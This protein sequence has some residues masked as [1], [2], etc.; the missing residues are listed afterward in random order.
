MEGVKGR[1]MAVA[2]CAVI[3]GFCAVGQGRIF[4]VDDDAVGAG[5][6]SSWGDAFVS[7]LDALSVAVSGDEIHVA[8]GTYKPDRGASFIPPNR[9]ETFALV[10]GVALLGGYAGVLTL[11]PD[12]RDIDRYETILSGDL[13]GDDGPDFTNYDDNS[14]QGVVIARGIRDADTAIEGFTITGGNGDEG[15][16]IICTES[17][18]Q[19]RQCKVLGNR[20][21]GSGG[22]MASYGGTLVLTDCAFENNRAGYHGGGLWHEGGVLSLAQCS[23]E[24]NEAHGHGGGL[25]AVETVVNLLQCAFRGNAGLSDSGGRGRVVSSGGGMYIQP[26]HGSACT[27]CSFVGNDAKSHGGGAYVYS[28]GVITFHDCSFEDNSA[29]RGGGLANQFGDGMAMTDCVFHNNS[30]QRDGGGIQSQGNLALTRCIF[31]RNTASRG[32]G[33]ETTFSAPMLRDCVFADNIA[34]DTD[35]PVFGGGAIYLNGSPSNPSRGGGDGIV[36]DMIVPILVGCRFAGNRAIG[37]SGGALF[38]GAIEAI[39]TNCIFIGNTASDGGGV[40]SY[41]FGTTLRYCTLAQNRSDRISGISDDVGQSVC[42]H[43]IVW[44]HTGA[45]LSDSVSASFSDI[46]HGWPGEGN[47]DV[48]PLFA[49]PGYWGYDVDNRFVPGKDVWVDGD[50]HLVSQAG[51]WDPEAEA[52]VR[53]EVTSPCIDAGNPEGPIGDELFPNGGIANMGA[54]GGSTQASKTYF[55]TEPAEVHLAGDINGDGAVG[56]ADLLIV[57]LQWTEESTP[58][59]SE[60]RGR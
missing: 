48:D 1:Q 46:E 4:Y 25:Y 40:F 9:D 29:E 31:T 3:L 27:N 44:D 36:P 51:R 35:E 15:G 57:I 16:G 33:M 53:D 23:W 10:D 21:E 52:W 11:D 5:D 30:A 37:S 43:C 22:G 58:T 34:C 42:D 20:A 49:A 7:P 19:V 54:Y 55:G 59:E 14:R 32:G 13:K 45:V 2:L 56:V 50:Y 26:E 24:G 12:A 60:G 39:L 38:N 41:G 17:S 28:T 8:Q 18:L 47:M 6:G